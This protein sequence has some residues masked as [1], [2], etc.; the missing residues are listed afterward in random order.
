MKIWPQTN[1]FLVM[2]FEK[3]TTLLPKKFQDVMFIDFSLY[4]LQYFTDTEW[5]Q[6]I[7]NRTQQIILIYDHHLEALANFWDHSSFGKHRIKTVALNKLRS[8]LVMSDEQAPEFKIIR[9]NTLTSQEL[10]ILHLMLTGKNANDIS[11]I[12]ECSRG[13]VYQLK[14]NVEYK[15]DVR[16]RHLGR[17][18][19]IQNSNAL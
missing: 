12:L 15:L 10:L 3:I 7:N 8:F 11:D 9:K 14:K 4:N 5:L 18:I 16:F 6:E 19:K 13:H 2:G 17:K 1:Q